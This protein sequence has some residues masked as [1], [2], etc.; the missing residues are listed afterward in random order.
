MELDHVFLLCAVDA[1]ERAALARLG[2]EDVVLQ[3]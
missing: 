3:G 2:L 1:P